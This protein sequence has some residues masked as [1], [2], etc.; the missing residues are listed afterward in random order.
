[1]Q[2]L[3]AKFL[4]LQHISQDDLKK[5]TQNKIIVIPLGTCCSCAYI[6]RNHTS[7]VQKSFAFDWVQ[8]N[9]LTACQLLQSNHETIEIFFKEF[10]L[11]VDFDNEGRHKKTGSKFPHEQKD[12]KEKG[13]DFV[14]EKYIKRMKRL[15]DEI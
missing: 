1:M 13:Y 7:L 6:C 11:S 2:E 8:L 14:V 12:L 5:Y 9:V 15:N 4:T 10:F 3:H